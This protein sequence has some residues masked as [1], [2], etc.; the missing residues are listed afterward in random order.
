MLSSP[1]FLLG[2]AFLLTHELDAVRCEEWR[3]FP[4]LSALRER[5][6]YLVFTAL[7]IPL[8]AL[9]LWAFASA[10]TIQRGIV[11]GLDS[12]FVIH[13]LLHLILRDHPGNRFNSA[14]SW[15]LFGGAGLCGALDLLL[16]LR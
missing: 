16:L 15:L 9:L 1:L 10:D 7:H 5:S 11:V 6:G 2:C 13:L 3:I 12:F 14:F 8:F 4:I